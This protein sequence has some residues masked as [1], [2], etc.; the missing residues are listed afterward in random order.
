MSM[1]IPLAMFISFNKATRLHYAK[2]IT[3]SQAQGY[4]FV[5]AAGPG[6]PHDCEGARRDAGARPAGAGPGVAP[7][8]GPVRVA[9]P[10]V[11]TRTRGGGGAHGGGAARVFL[12]TPTLP[13]TMVLGGGRASSAGGAPGGAA[14]THGV[15]RAMV[16]GLSAVH[17]RVARAGAR[18]ARV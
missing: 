7:P 15:A 9:A 18:A 10:P 14:R 4:V 5:V 8:H 12:D 6:A 13:A 17:G 11:W 3:S 2:C 16:G 1:T